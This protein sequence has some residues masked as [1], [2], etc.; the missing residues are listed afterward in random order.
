MSIEKGIVAYL[1]VE[2]AGLVSTRI[3]N[4]RYP[5]KVTLPAVRFQRIST[6]RVLS[7]DQDN[8]GLAQAR[9]QFDVEADSFEDAQEIVDAM[10]EALSGYTGSMGS[11][12]V[13]SC[14]PF[15]EMDSPGEVELKTS[16]KMLDYMIVYQE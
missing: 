13:R 9:F 6:A 5:Q 8:T 15:G 7:H 3:Y 11:E 14:L 10:H 2:L 4:N 12:T 16:V 1:R